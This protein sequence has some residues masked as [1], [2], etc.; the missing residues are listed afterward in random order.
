MA[1]LTFSVLPGSHTLLPLG[2]CECSS[3]CHG[4]GVGWTHWAECFVGW[5]W[6]T[7]T[8]APHTIPAHIIS[9]NS[10]QF[11][12]I[13]IN[14]LI[15]PSCYCLLI[16]SLLESSLLY[17]HRFVLSALPLFCYKIITACLFPCLQM[18]CNPNCFT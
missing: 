16:S 13:D 10:A 8:A 17:T 18:C 1:A 15:G 12:G 7:F 6:G 4:S 11:E 2:D 5:S 3:Q 9:A 14:T